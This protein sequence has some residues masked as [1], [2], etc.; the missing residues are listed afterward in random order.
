[1]LGGLAVA[2]GDSV[3][4]GTREAALVALDNHPQL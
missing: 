3:A 2:I 1:M 4:A